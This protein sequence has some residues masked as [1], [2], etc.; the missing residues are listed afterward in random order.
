MSRELCK[1]AIEGSIIAT[2]YAE[3]LLNQAIRRHGEDRPVAYP[4]TAYRL[5][6]IRSLSGEETP[7]IGD[8]PKVLNK[9]KANIRH[10]PTFENAKLAG[11][12]TLFAAEII[13]A[14]K[15]INGVAPY[16]DPYMGF[17]SDGVLR[18]L[19]VPLVD[20]TI[21]GV[22]V[23]IG[24]A[25][26]S[27]AAVQL[28]RE[29]QKKGILV[30]LVNNIIEQL[31]DEG[32]RLGVDYM[33]FPL[34]HFTA[35]IH[36]VNFALRA[37]L[38]FGN[39]PP[40]NRDQ[41]LKYQAERVDAFVLALGELDEVRIAAEFGAI[42]LGFPVVS[43]QP[44]EEIPGKFVYE[45]DYVKMVQ[46]ALELR[47]I[48]IK[49]VDIPIPVTY[50]PAFEGERI[51]KEDMYVEF[52][53][54]RS[55]AF[56]L[57]QMKS[58]DEVEDGRIT[59]V[60]PDVDEIPAGTAMPLGLVVDVAGRKMQED[61]EP[62]LE[63]RIHY[64]INY[65]EGCWHIA[66]R[67]ICWLRISKDAVSRGFKIKHYGDILYAKFKSDFP[68]IVDRVQVTILTDEAQVLEHVELA[69]KKYAARDARLRGLTD[70]AVDTF[71]SCTLCQSFAPNHV[72]IVAPE[73]SGLCGAVSWLD[74]KAS[75]EITPTGP[76]QPILKGECLDEVKGQWKGV[77]EFLYSASHR[78]LES[79]NLY[80]LM[81]NPMT[82]CGCFEC[83][84]AILPEANGVMIVNREYPGQ[85][86]CGMKFSTLAGT[87][88]GGVQTPGFMGHGRA[89]VASRKFIQA[90]GGLA[91]VVWMPSEL[92]EFL[93]EDILRRSEGLGL[94]DFYDKIADEK[95]GTTIEQVLPF[96]EEK[97]HPALSMPPLL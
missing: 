37:G 49:I 27:K 38:A 21:P 69:R 52:G 36:A 59:V 83:I 85:T 96:L 61:F 54:G 93:R 1:A 40:G 47:N 94:V 23:I 80:T 33:A 2:S 68:A 77:N 65:C 43:D 92:K 51:R 3:I 46:T 14:L 10:E 6:V 13:E 42:H 91:R 87:V 63:R 78:T 26:D 50:G 16:N 66:Q 32:M 9:F 67:D 79:V 7:V 55:P 22:A 25:Q 45:P 5:P 35:A 73:R 12:A 97:G 70:E 20:D 64:F 39:V 84:M 11:E 58:M 72:C 17:V 28:F 48:K 60:G 56:E 86:P 30:I 19:G 62:V 15:Y 95:V 29:L 81:E 82:S 75:Y 89:Y 31:L 34:G 44:V 24:E 74:A 4:D 41:M 18:K 53:G 57:V 90:D 88:G 76:N 71:Y 8:L